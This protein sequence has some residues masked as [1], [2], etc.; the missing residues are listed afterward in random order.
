MCQIERY[1][2]ATPVIDCETI[3]IKEKARSLTEGQEEVAEKAKCLF[4]FVR[5]E[6][7]Y[8]PYS[9]LFPLHASAILEKRSGFCT[10]KAI[11][12]AALARA[13]GIPSR[14]GFADIRNHILTDKLANLLGTDLIV[15]HGYTELYIEAKWVKATPTFDLK[16]CQENRI[17][18]V[19]FDGK[20][21]AVFHS[22]NLDGKLHIEYVRQHGHYADAPLDDMINAVARAYGSKFLELWGLQGVDNSG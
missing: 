3:S 6:I 10:Q 21:H 15:H 8:D 14:L 22:H 20:N 11:L 19:E 17:I 5:D 4:Y 1:L 18:P 9:P 12:L 13:I 7:K 2:K 16:M